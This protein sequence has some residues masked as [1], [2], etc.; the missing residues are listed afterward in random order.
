MPE[1]DTTHPP[2]VEPD[3]RISRIRLSRKRSP[4]GNAGRG[5]DPV[6]PGIKPAPRLLLD[7]LAQLLSQL[8]KV[9]R[10][11]AP[12][13]RPRF[14]RSGMLVQAAFSSS[15]RSVVP[16]RPLGSTA[17][18]RFPAPLGLSD[19]RPEPSVR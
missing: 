9:P 2:L 17:L 8:R 13:G 3:V 18:T 6:I 15:Y 1:I 10:Q 5:L 7:L 19:S 4:V 14:V 12:R 11:T 16:V